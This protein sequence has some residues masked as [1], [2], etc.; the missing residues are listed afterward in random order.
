MDCPEKLYNLEKTEDNKKLVKQKLTSY[1]DATTRFIRDNGIIKVSRST[2]QLNL[3]INKYI[4]EYT[5]INHKSPQVECIAR[6]F[7]ITEAEVVYAMDASNRPISLYSLVGD[8]NGK[9]QYLIEKIEDDKPIDKEM[10]NELLYN[11]IKDLPE[12]DRKIIILRYFRDK[13]QKEIA[14]EL[15]V[16]QVQVSRLE[17]KILEKLKTKLQ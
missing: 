10:D 8:D 9:E 6:E 14:L 7:N 4:E 16:S 17:N 12:R 1:V 2:K 3:K 11:V 15:G 5:S 13:T